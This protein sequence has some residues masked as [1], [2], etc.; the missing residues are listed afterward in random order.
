MQNQF[1]DSPTGGIVGNIDSALGRTTARVELGQ[2]EMGL[3]LPAPQA[4]HQ[5]GNGRITP[6]EDE[7][8][9]RFHATVRE[10]RLLVQI[11]KAFMQ[12][13]VARNRRH[14][15]QGSYFRRKSGFETPRVDN[16]NAGNGNREHACAKGRNLR[17]AGAAEADR[18][19][20][21]SVSQF[22]ENK[23]HR[24][25][26]TPLKVRQRAEFERCGKHQQWPVPE[27]ERIAD[28]AGRDD[29]CGRREI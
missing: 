17:A 12:P 15:G 27:V 28:A 5:R 3:L 16:R 6:G 8:P 11:E 20:D 7:R 13:L 22:G 9:L 10:R 25:D 24:D 1:I 21:P 18:L 26:Q 23:A 19:L 14:V 4:G 2:T 29:R